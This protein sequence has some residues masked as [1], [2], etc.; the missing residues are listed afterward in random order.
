MTFKLDAICN[1]VIIV[2][3]LTYDDSKLRKTIQNKGHLMSIQPD[4]VTFPKGFKRNLVYTMFL[5]WY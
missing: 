2:E 1:V 4:H 3:I 5:P